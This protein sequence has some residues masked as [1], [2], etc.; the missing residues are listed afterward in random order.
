MGL[1]FSRIIIVLDGSF[2]LLIVVFGEDF[3]TTSRNTRWKEKVADQRY[4]EQFWKCH[5]SLEG[6]EE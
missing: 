5:M 1:L 2:F 4:V 3:I 6:Y